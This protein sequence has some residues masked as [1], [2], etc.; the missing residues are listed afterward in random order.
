MSVGYANGI[1][2][3]SMTHTGEP[4]FMLYIPIEV[5]CIDFDLMPTYG[6]FYLCNHILYMTQNVMI[7][8]VWYNP[9]MYVQSSE[10][11]LHFPVCTACVQWSDV[12][13]AEIRDQECWLLRL[14]ESTNREILCILGAGSGLV[15]H[16]TRVWQRIPCQIWQ[17]QTL[18]LSLEISVAVRF[19]LL[20]SCLI[21]DGER[22]P[23]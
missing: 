19:G 15:H 6:Y 5:S 12:S 8:P 20:T 10:I 7:C 13:R 22:E 3:M 23:T 14:A 1:R 16:P 17:G 4:G 18:V 9:I 21:S 2:V 11:D